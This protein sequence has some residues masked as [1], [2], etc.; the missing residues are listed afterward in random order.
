MRKGSTRKPQ[1]DEPATPGKNYITPNGLERLKDEHRFLLTRERPAVT[2]V[3]A[4]AAAQGDRSENA[5]YIYGKRRLREI[6]RRVRFL[7]KRLDE[8][9]IVI[10]P[11]SDPNRVFFGAYVTI[12]NDDG[13]RNTYR[14]VGGDE[15]DTDKGWI[16]IDSPVARA[17][18]GKR[19]DDVVMVRAPKGEIEYTIV[20]VS[21]A[22]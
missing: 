11:P 19:P 20:T 7:S 9:T 1:A 12:E 2:Q 10:E 18:L 15:H 4:W 13:V 21:Y 17:C 8:V 3:V 16:S 6:D 14:I 5:E 22:P